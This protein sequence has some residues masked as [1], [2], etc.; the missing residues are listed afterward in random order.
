MSGMFYILRIYMFSS[1]VQSTII[2]T[3]NRVFLTQILFFLLL[4]LVFLNYILNYYHLTMFYQGGNIGFSSL[5]LTSSI[6]HL[7]A[8][9]LNLIDVYIYPFIY[10]FLIVTMLSIIF[11]MSYNY[12][13]LINFM[14]F[15]QIIFLAGYLFF[16][17]T[18]IIIFFFAYEMLLVPSFFILYKFAKTRRCVEAAYLMFFWTQFGALFLIFAL[19]YLF[20][21][22][23]SS[24]FIN[25]SSHYFSVFEVNFLFL[26][27]LAGF[28]VKLPIWPFYGWLPKAH[29]EASTNFSIFLSG[30]LVKFAFFGLLKCLV[31][32]ELEPSFIY[33]YPFLML[34]IVDAVFKLFYQI[35][36]KKL[37]AYST[38]VEMHWLTICI[39]S[40]Q[41][42]LML[43]SFCMLI[44]H[45]LISTNS[46][47]LVDAIA[48]R[49]KTRLITEI[50]G[51]NYLC[52][53]LFL[54]AL[55]N[56]LIFLGFPGSI[57]FISEVL[58]FSFFFDL[59]PGAALFLILFL[60]LL[61]PTFFLRS[62]MNALF[63][64]SHRLLLQLPTDLS[65]RE[66]ILFLGLPFLMYWL[67]ISWQA[68][69]V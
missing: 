61:G 22:C 52:P 10:I 36:L 59:Y 54:A 37:V 39:I 34:G 30:V 18:S 23:G 31:T 41:S 16:F 38:V 56:L 63:G 9:S 29:V 43:A 55:L 3:L 62:W 60:Y 12:D 2:Q 42:N 66:L 19:L 20:F 45:A 35:D 7:D 58:F 53:K 11:C 14:V 57:F 27:F 24:F 13:E 46:F 32:L 26:C 17:T 65:Y 68:F 6:C 21:L 4:F 69:V 47:L 64:F 50:H 25:I 1:L 5:I 51:I 28:G 49:F 15:Y 67:G 33:A 44:S 40:G 8:L 48:R